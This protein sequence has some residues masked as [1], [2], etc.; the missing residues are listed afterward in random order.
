L[1][2][3]LGEAGVG[4]KIYQITPELLC[5]LGIEDSKKK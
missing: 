5:S 2:F 4:D 1:E 3:N